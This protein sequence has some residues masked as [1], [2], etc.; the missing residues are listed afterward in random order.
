MR[1][2][3]QIRRNAKRVIQRAYENHAYNMQKWEHACERRWTLG[4][5]EMMGYRAFI[6]IQR[7]AR[8]LKEIGLRF[9]RDP[10]GTIIVVR[11]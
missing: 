7:A 2:P 9:Y 6:R 5:D 3:Q 11:A 1:T 10:D 4:P 8:S